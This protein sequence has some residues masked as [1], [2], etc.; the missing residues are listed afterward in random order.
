MAA[1]DE[2]RDKLS[3]EQFRVCWQKGTERPFSGILLHNTATGDYHCVCC[4]RPLFPSTSKYD[5]G[6]G[7]PSFYASLAGAVQLS[8]DRSHGM[9]RTEVCC[10]GCGAHLGHVFDDGPAP[11]GLRYCINSVSLSFAADGD[12]SDK[13]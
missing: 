4:D 10:A 9:I 3:G 7:W 6:C 12:S 2:W 1:G 8:E 11:T 5:A 13:A